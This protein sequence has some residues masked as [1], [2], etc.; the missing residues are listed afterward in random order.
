MCPT[1]PAKPLPTKFG[2]ALD[3]F[4]INGMIVWKCANLVG[5]RME[6]ALVNGRYELG[7]RLGGGAFCEVYRARDRS[8]DGAERAL[9]VLR[10]K[11]SA[12]DLLWEFERLGRL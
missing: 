5:V 9:K 4:E 3:C 12:H 6:S 8:R 11:A 1:S 2:W 7:P 10:A